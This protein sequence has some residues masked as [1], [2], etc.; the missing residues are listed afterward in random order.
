MNIFMTILFASLTINKSSSEIGSPYS[1]YNNY[2][3]IPSTFYQP[4]PEVQQPTYKNYIQVFPHNS[5]FHHSPPIATQQ[6][7][8]IIPS[9]EITG[10]VVKYPI[11]SDI[12]A[13]FN[14]NHQPTVIAK[15]P[16]TRY[17]HVHES[18]KPLITKTVFIHAAPEETEEDIDQE[19][20]Q[21]AQ[22][23][24]K[25]YNV[26]FVKAPSQTSKATALNLVK[27]LKEEKTVVYVLSKKTTAADLQDAIADT[28]RHINKPEVFFIKYRTHEEAANAQKEILTQYDSLGGS[29]TIVDEGV[30]PTTSVVDSLN[31]HDSSDIDDHLQH[32]DPAPQEIAI[33]QQQP[34]LQ[35]NH[36][37]ED[38]VVKAFLTTNKGYL[39]P[40]T[41]AL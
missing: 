16:Q 4:P 14:F 39:P 22:Q 1:Y 41:R 24:R 2:N 10:A 15:A 35:K 40:S 27:G 37:E 33:A 7:K 28:P 6:Q 25:H 8:F 30:A 21:L 23:P 12:S 17:H 29:T 5:H 9:Q 3:E 31:V 18:K 19:A 13:H 11:P 20:I 32:I 34:Q 26:I 36:F 38:E